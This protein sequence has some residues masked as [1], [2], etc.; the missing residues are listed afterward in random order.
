MEYIFQST[1]NEQSECSDIVFKERK[2]WNL[3]SCPELLLT[4]WEFSAACQGDAELVMCFG[5]F[6]YKYNCVLQI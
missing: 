4:V 1:R 5:V 6:V 3:V 2:S